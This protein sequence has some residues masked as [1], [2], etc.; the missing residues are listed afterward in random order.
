[1]A[2]TKSIDLVGFRGAVLGGGS[3]SVSYVGDDIGNRGVALTFGVGGG[4]Y[5][6]GHSGWNGIVK[7]ILNLSE[8]IKVSQ[9]TIFDQRGGGAEAV[10]GTIIGVSYNMK[11]SRINGVELG[12]GAA[13]FK[14]YTFVFPFSSGFWN[15]PDDPAR[16]T[17]LPAYHWRP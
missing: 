5:L 1:M 16:V 12:V 8:R 15:S 14:T 9:G 11:Q 6:G 3:V 2:T 13:T 7:W 17:T 4:F 10:G